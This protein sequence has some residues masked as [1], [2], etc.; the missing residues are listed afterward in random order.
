VREYP[1]RALVD[2][3]VGAVDEHKLFLRLTEALYSEPW[4]ALLWTDAGTLGVRRE[5]PHASARGK[6]LPL[7]IA[8][9]SGAS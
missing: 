4:T 1:D 2:P 8:C 7:H 6:I 3:A 5:V 9:R